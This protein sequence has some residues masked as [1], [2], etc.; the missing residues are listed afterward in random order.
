MSTDEEAQVILAALYVKDLLKTAR[1]HWQ[2]YEDYLSAEQQV[3]FW[4]YFDS[5]ERTMLKNHIN[6]SY[7][8][9]VRS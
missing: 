8:P 9:A 1:D 7:K 6:G 4:E 2:S 3:M 5:Q